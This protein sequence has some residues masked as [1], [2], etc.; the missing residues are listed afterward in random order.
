M[1]VSLRHSFALVVCVLANSWSAFAAID[2]PTPFGKASDGKGVDAYTLTNDKGMLAKVMTFGAVLVDLQVPDKAGK[3]DSI[4]LGYDNLKSYEKGS[5]YGATVG[6]FA[7]RI[8]DARFTLDGKEYKLTSNIHGGK[9]GFNRVHWNA[10]PLPAQNAIRFNYLSMDGEE[11]FPGSLNVTVTYTLTHQNE[12]RI[13]Y[14]ATT[15]KPTTVNLTNHSYFNLGGP[16]SKSVLDHVLTLNATTYTVFD[17]SLIPTGAIAPVD[18]TPLDFT[19][20]KKI[21]DGYDEQKKAGLKAGYDHNFVLPGKTGQL[22]QAARIAEPLSGR[23][24]TVQTD[25]PGMQL[26]TANGNAICFETQHHPN[27]VNIPHF[28]STILR[29]GETFRSTTVFAFAHE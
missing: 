25:Q 4:V 16:K 5:F 29:P 27:S 17:K 3:P 26:Y 15:D 18:G 14:L 19:K 7:N 28:P 9:R 23:V 1:N 8:K 22:A 24:M 10:E 21:A 12:L 20:A 13:D 2:G 6:R 11:G